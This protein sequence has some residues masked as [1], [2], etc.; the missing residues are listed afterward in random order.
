M[1]ALS[2]KLRKAREIKVEAG[3]FTFIVRRPT[4]M[5][6]VELRG[7]KFARAILPY[8]V[9][10]EGVTEIAVLGTG[11]PHPVDFDQQACSE[12]LQDRLDILGSVVNAVFDAYSK[13]TEKLAE[14]V[15]N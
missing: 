12:W 2:E 15:K 14:S 4:D 7:E 1:S 13:H 9:G 11:A 5:E 8:I 10:W 6:M 3:G